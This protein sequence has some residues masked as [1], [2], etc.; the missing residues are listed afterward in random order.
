MSRITVSIY[1]AMYYRLFNQVTEAIE[2]IQR[3]NAVEAAQLL[4]AAQQEAEETYI[5]GAGDE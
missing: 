1:K 4:L 5:S 2:E 3:G